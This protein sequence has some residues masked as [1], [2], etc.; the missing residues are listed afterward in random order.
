MRTALA[1]N[2]AGNLQQATQ[3]VEEAIG[4]M[5]EIAPPKFDA[6]S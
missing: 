2:K 4:D 3:S 5:T 1:K 6:G